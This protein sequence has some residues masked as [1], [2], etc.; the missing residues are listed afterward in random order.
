MADMAALAQ[1]AKVNKKIIHFCGGPAGKMDLDFRNDDP[2]TMLML[3]IIAFSAEM[4]TWNITQR[5][6][7]SRATLRILKRYAG[8]WTPFGYQPVTKGEGT[9]FELEPDPDY[10][11]VL[12]QMIDKLLGG[13]GLTAI[14][15]WL[16]ATGIPTSKDLVRIRNGKKSAGLKWKYPAVTAVLRSRA[17]CGITE[18]YPDWRDGTHPGTAEIVYGNDGMPLRFADP[19]VND[20]T[21]RKVQE[22]LDEISRPGSRQRGDSPWL[23]GV[24]VC[25]VCGDPLWA[26]RQTNRGKL[27]LY[28]RCDNPKCERR[29]LP[30][31][32]L[33]EAIE[34]YIAQHWAHVPYSRVNIT[35]GENHEE[36]IREVKAAMAD[37]GGKATVKEALG[38]SADDER[39][40][41]AILKTR[42]GI[43]IHLPAKED[44]ITYE[45]TGISLAQHWASLDEAGKHAFLMSYSAKVRARYGKPLP[46]VDIMSGT[47]LMGEKWQP[48]IPVKLPDFEAAEYGTV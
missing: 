36:E 42:L 30:Y 27:Y 15:D 25:K 45:Q 32:K 2:M 41:L 33:E 21:W 4:E 43:L 9:G 31:G 24:S 34:Q 48:D 35:Q 28:M 20:D 14:A 5:A 7:G 16:N 10:A 39:A 37:L 12:I 8:G 19:I 46:D 18:M 22:R 47:L 13:Y 26:K 44:R 11:P 23:T 3:Q 40:K 1:W 38:E 6:L 17:M 29:Q